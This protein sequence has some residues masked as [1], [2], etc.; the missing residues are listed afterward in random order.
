M[1]VRIP[2]SQ[3]GKVREAFWKE[4]M[5]RFCLTRYMSIVDS[6]KGDGKKSKEEREGNMYWD[7][8]EM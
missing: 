8:S 2:A 6:T 5:S 1:E 4:E 7:L 3:R